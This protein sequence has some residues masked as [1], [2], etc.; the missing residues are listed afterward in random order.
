[1]ILLSA[2]VLAL[3][4]ATQDPAPPAV[5]V[6]SVCDISQEFTFYMDGRF[7]TQYLKE[8]GRDARNWGSLHAL[9]LSNTNLLVLTAGDGHIAYSPAAI[10]HVDGF[11]RSGGTVLLMA[12]GAEKMPPGA[13]LAEHFGAKLTTL[14]AKV[15]LERADER[16]A[17][18]TEVTFRRG[19]VVDLDDRHHG[20]PTADAIECTDRPTISIVHAARHH[21][22]MR[23]RHRLVG[24]GQHPRQTERSEPDDPDALTFERELRVDEP[25]RQRGEIQRTGPEVQVRDE[26]N[27]ERVG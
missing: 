16:L 12:D 15:P 21:I 10:E 7:H 11:A 5:V 14:A 1:M 8:V 20:V 24:D 19:T 9:E 2:V 23:I 26:M 4:V 17:E 13:V 27:P 6:H 3:S 25:S 18:G 22:T